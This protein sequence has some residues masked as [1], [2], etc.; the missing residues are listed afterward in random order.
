M[1][2]CLAALDDNQLAGAF[3]HGVAQ[4]GEPLSQL[5]P[6]ALL[7]SLNIPVMVPAP[8][9]DIQLTF[10]GIDLPLF[11]AFAPAVRCLS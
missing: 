1:I 8:E 10:I 11:K 6:K 9:V 3:M 2:S 4:L 7:L 5:R